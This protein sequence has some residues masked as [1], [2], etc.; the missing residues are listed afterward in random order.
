MRKYIITLLLFVLIFPSV[1]NAQGRKATRKAKKV[2]V[3]ENP[4]ITQMLNAV[5]QVT[6]IDSLVVSVSD[7]YSHIPLSPECGLLLQKGGVGQYT[8]ELGDHRLEAFYQGDSITFLTT[9]DFIGGQWTDPV[10]VKGIGDDSANHPYVMPDGTTLYYAQKGEKSIGGYDIFVTRYNSDNATYLRPENIGMPFASEA[11]DYLYVIDEPMQLGYFVTDRRQPENMVC[12]YV[13]IPSA[14]RRVY[15]SEAYSPEKLRSLATIN[16]IS[17]TWDDGDERNK[18]LQRLAQ[19]RQ[20]FANKPVD[21]TNNVKQLSELD[22]MRQ[23]AELKRKALSDERKDY[24]IAT[25]EAKAL[26]K[27][28]ILKA[29][30]DLEELLLQIRQKEKEERNKTI[31][32]SL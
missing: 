31:N 26:M 25:P 12:I 24:S 22:A 5:Q 18:A 10:P 13:F 30:K 29:E 19:A 28:S 3:V 4:L 9:S 15:Q 16:S 27:E 14:S 32:P 1:G 11:N 23:K 2:E 20:S 8:S 7:F 6:F 17:D 21:T